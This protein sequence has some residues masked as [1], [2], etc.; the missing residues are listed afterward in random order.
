MVRFKVIKGSHLLLGISVAVLLAVV[1]FIVL[2]PQ[3]AA[4]PAN[5]QTSAEAKVVQTFASADAVSIEIIPDPKPTEAVPAKS[6]LIYHTH[7]HEA[8]E[9]DAADP[10][11][12]I[13][14]WRTVDHE[15]SIVRVGAALAEELSQRGFHVVHDITDHEL[16]NLSNSYVRSLE[17]LESYVEN[18]DLYIDLHRD[19]YV[20]GM[21]PCLD[22]DK[23]YAQLMLLVGRGDK[24]APDVRPDY[25]QNL[26]FAQRLTAA[27]NRIQEGICRNVTV[28]TGRYN[29][30]IGAP[31]ILIEFGHNKNTLK[32]ALNSVPIAAEAIAQMLSAEL[33]PQNHQ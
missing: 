3:N 11:E 7:T 18:F 25:E 14:T 20:S 32:Q 22:S 31:S 6:I 16:D 13:E 33:L 29:Q 30:H 1:L 10:Y 27:M 2:Q 23:E 4:H 19:A 24:H 5:V 26:A 9:Q 17:T 28:K 21:L 12:A 15:H 8:Y